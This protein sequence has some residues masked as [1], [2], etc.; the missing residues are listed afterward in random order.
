M[1]IENAQEL[2][3]SLSAPKCL[4]LSIPPESRNEIYRLVFQKP[5][6]KTDMLQADPPSALPLLICRQVYLEASLMY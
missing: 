3:N 6:K 4:F 2:S 1:E 5:F